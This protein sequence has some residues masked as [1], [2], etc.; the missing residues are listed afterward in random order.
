MLA[1]VPDP[2]TKKALPLP[3]SFVVDD[4]PNDATGGVTI[5]IQNTGLVG[6]AFSVHNYGVNSTGKPMRCGHLV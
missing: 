5:S 3:Y 1:L 6:A 2:G 4:A